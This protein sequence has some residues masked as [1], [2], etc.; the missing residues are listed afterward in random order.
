MTIKETVE[1]IAR[2]V[3][4]DGRLAW[5]ASKPDGQPR[6]AVDGSRAA[7]LLGWRASMDFEQGLRNTI[8]WYLDNREH[9]R[10]RPARQLTTPAATAAARY[11]SASEAV[12][13]WALS[14]LGFGTTNSRAPSNGL[15]L[16]AG[17]ALGWENAVRYA[18][19]PA[20]AT[21]TGRCSRTNARRLL[22]A[23]SQL[24]GAEF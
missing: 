12:V 11:A 17:T 1:T 4:F 3:D 19:M 7:D 9:G 15:G 6:R 8:E 22:A 16:L 24:V 23:G 5:D 21:T 2:L 13:S 20:M 14:P 10:T 18:V